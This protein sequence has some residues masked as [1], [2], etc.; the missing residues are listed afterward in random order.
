MRNLIRLGSVCVSLL[1]VL[2]MRAQQ[3]DEIYN[4]KI[5]EYTT[6][7]KFL[8]ASVLN[9]PD[10]P[11]IPFPRKVFGDIIGAPGM[12]HHT[13]EIYSYYKQL[14]DASP[15]LTMKQVGITEEGRAINMV[16]I[17]N[18][19]AINRMDHYKNQLALLADPRK[20]NAGDVEKIIIDSKPVFYLNGG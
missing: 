3:I 9:L 16:V 2:D 19:D 14:D 10:D 1:F 15:F 8:P 6:D 5:R 7:P 17:G 12:M 20:V 4:Q 18:E 11:R 13:A